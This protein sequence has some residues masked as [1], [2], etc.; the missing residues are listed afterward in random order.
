MTAA[1]EARTRINRRIDELAQF[2][3]NELWLMTCLARARIA[4]SVGQHMR[5]MREEFVRSAK[6]M[7]GART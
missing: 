1:A 7:K 4:R 5:R 6:A 3:Q 2:H